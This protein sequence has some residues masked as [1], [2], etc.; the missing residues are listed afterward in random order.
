MAVFVRLAARDMPAM[1]VACV[2]FTG[3]LLV[4]LLATRGRE[5][6]PQPGSVP[7]L[8]VRGL[9]GGAAITFYYLAIER[10]GAS[11][12]TLLHAIYPV[13][14]ALFA[15]IV[16]REAFTTR[17]GLALATSAMGAT[18]ALGGPAPHGSE[19]VLG[20]LFGLL[21]GVLAGAAVATASEL[22]RTESASVVT[23]W[24]MAVG[25]LMTV[26]SFVV[27]APERVP[28]FALAGVVL[29]SVGG[30]W[31]LHYGLG[32]VSA[33]TGSLAV[34]TSVAATAV[35]ETAFLGE[36]LAGHV[37][38]G[39]VLMLAAVGLASSGRRRA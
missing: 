12:A 2:R 25:A 23:T 17:V 29:T 15:V 21:G 19:V 36:H 1:Q 18:V 32:Y 34:A 28:L 38:V 5:L 8:V 39:G 37:V 26:P 16:F 27:G 31:L 24:F 3:S 22:R 20:G 6:R 4:L 11:L 30:Q 9:L 14:T 10:A 7:R 13:F 33:I 35:L